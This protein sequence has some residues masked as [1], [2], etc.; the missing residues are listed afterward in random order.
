MSAVYKRS[1]T[2]F[3]RVVAAGSFNK[4]AESA[5][6]TAAAVI[7][8]INQ[9]EGELRFPLFHRTHR[10]LVLTDAGRLF[11][12]E[13]KTLTETAD[14]AVRRAQKRATPDAVIRVGTSPM[15]PAGF[16]MPLWSKIHAA[17]PELE[18]Q[19]VPFENTPNNARQILAN[20]GDTID[21]VPG[22]YD[23][24]LLQLRR[25]SAAELTRVTFCVAVSL[26]H[27][28][29]HKTRLTVADLAGEHLYL[30]RPGW[31]SAIDGLRTWLTA[32]HPEICLEDFDFYS[33]S[34]FNQS[35]QKDAVLLA[36]PYWKTTHPLLKIIPVDW[37]FTISFGFLH[38][39]SPSLK[40]ERFLKAVQ[41]AACDAEL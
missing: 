35:Q 31:S 11:A 21:V 10:G 4:A 36:V 29:A 20:L 23:E 2:T 34:V 13:M 32:H 8:Q 5:N 39:P 19:M 37:P 12:D 24:R 33:L 1:I 26:T 30:M 6:L 38:A 25:C 7:K 22:I 18:L 3:L 27:R 16:L 28:L 41:T 14:Q 15:T 17:E 9:L 40:V